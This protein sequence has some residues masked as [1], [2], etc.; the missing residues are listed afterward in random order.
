M[1]FEAHLAENDLIPSL[2][3]MRPN[4]SDLVIN[5]GAFDAG[6]YSRVYPDVMASG[7]TPAAHFARY[8]QW[9]GRG[10]SAQRPNAEQTSAI[11]KTLRAKRQVSYCIPIM[12]RPDDIKQTLRENLERNR[13]HE[14]K[15]EFIVLFL[16]EDVGTHQWIQREFVSDLISGYL[17]LIISPPL[18]RWHFGRA[19][20]RFR[21]V[22]LGDV[23]SS[24]D[25]DN[26]VTAEETSQLL[27]VM[28]Q[29]S[30]RFVFHH[31]SGNWGDGTSGR[32]SLPRRF[33]EEV[34]YDERLLPRQF[35]EVDLLIS[36]MVRYP[37][38]TFVRNDT[39]ENIFSSQRMQ[40]FL[41]DRPRFPPRTHFV[42]QLRREMPGNP[43]GADYVAVNEQMRTMT[44]YNQL[45]SFWKNAVPSRRNRFVPEIFRARQ[46]VLDAMP[47]HD[48]VPVIV[49]PTST[50]PL[51][52]VGKGE[53]ALFCCVK[54][55]E[56]YLPA[57]YEHY[58]RIGVRHF[59]F[60]DDE[61]TIPVQSVLPQDDVHVFRPQVGAFATS[62]GLWLGALIK[63]FLDEGMWALTCD[64]D[65]FLDL[66]PGHSTLAP[67]ISE[68][69]NNKQFAIP[70]ILLD[71]VPSR[72]LKP[73]RKK[74]D[75]LLRALD[76]HAL[77]RG[78]P[79]TA[80]LGHSS[81]KWGFGPYGSL[82][83]MLDVRYHA[84]GTFDSLRKIPLFRHRAHLHLNQGFHDLH[85]TDKT[86]ELGSK[87]WSYQTVLP[88]RH[89]KTMKLFESDLFQRTQ[90]YVETKDQAYHARTTHNISKIFGSGQ[91]GALNALEKVSRMRYTP[92]EFGRIVAS[93]QKAVHAR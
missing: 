64:A 10:I 1:A 28:S 23:Y 45:V 49:S 89:Y 3:K 60:V 47:R 70:G 93:A 69:E 83:W 68:A 7:M 51:P 24:L 85:F 4:I 15:I 36:I 71:M 35:D 78:A 91:E 52:K 32:V 43:R 54:N 16:D 59:F 66:A 33:Y 56:Q 42:P 90:V 84:F 9:L 5:S 50:H 65:E 39:K 2:E 19:K 21:G 63:C 67:I 6:W 25:G 53:L 31:F 29:F 41:I 61:S 26:F 22:I 48:L 34:R 75:E 12:N 87:I 58:R 44:T 74:T 20:N 77:V 86:P 81:V 14:D 13:T 46:Q 76:G 30:D 92:A 55:D 72:D 11:V 79:D 17:R 38:V 37:N 73:I 40:N 62:K 82:A 57:F 18:A 27:S 8:G 88:I 80:Y